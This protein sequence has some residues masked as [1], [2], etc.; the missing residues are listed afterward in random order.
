MKICWLGLALLAQ[1]PLAATPIEIRPLPVERPWFL[2]GGES[3]AALAPGE[4]VAVAVEVPSLSVKDANLPGAWRGILSVDLYGTTGSGE[5]KV[6]LE[7]ID[8]ASG[9]AF[10][11]GELQ[12]SGQA[13][14]AAWAPISSSE[15]GG[16]EVAKLF[17]GDKSTDWHSRYGANQPKP[18]HW[19]GVEFGSPQVIEGVRYLPRQSGFTNGVA[20]EY[21]VEVRRAGKSEWEVMEEGTSDRRRIAE[22]RESIDLRFDA[23]AKVE[24]FR[25]VVVSDWSGGGFGTAAELSAIGLELPARE[26]AVQA[27]NRVWLEV[28][29]D[30]LG[31]L[32]EKRFQLCLKASDGESVVAGT[33]RFCRIHEAPTEKL[34]G[35]SNGGTGPDKLG[36]GQLGF[37]GMTEH[38][39]TVLSVMRLRQGG[40]ADKAGLRVGDAIV[41]VSGMPLPVNDLNPGWTWF[42]QSHEAVLGHAAEDAL[43]SG[44][45]TLELGVLRDGAVTN[46]VMKLPRMKAF[47]TMDPANDPQAAVLLEDMLEWVRENQQPD[48]SWS[49]DVKRTTLASLALMATGKKKDLNQVKKAI[50]WGMAKYPTP[51]KHGNLGFWSGAYM[52][53][54]YSEWHLRTGDKRVLDALDAMRDWAFNGQHN[55]KWDV[56]ALGHGP[57]G[58]PY[59]QKALVAPAC[60]LLVFEALAQRCGMKSKLWELLM[61]YMEMAWSDPREGGHGAMG[62]NRSYKDLDEFWSR[63]GLFAMAAHL[64]GERQDMEDAMMQIM[65]ERRSWIRNSHAYGEPGGGLGLLGM[66]LC[67]PKRYQE[68]IKDYAWWFSMAWEPGYGL[69]FTTPHMGAPYMGEDDLMNVVY[70]LVLQGPKRSLHLTGLETK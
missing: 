41:S 55:S 66:N 19:V 32:T 42:H 65:Q 57:D 35:R 49:G 20:K 5:G 23:P 31:K 39:Q 43:T 64:R 33:P 34:L 53:I 37:D 8:P 62:Y 2:P 58:L 61:P 52:G 68:V 10:A 28:P 45:T 7:A 24:A 12:V 70:A 47:T 22:N 16:A 69:H 46:L 40:P 38:Q 51:E 11:K 21:R 44:K 17:D 15:Q 9:E 4:S 18:P 54:L 63:S 13:P 60:H 56:P 29:A 30:Q 1:A 50:D 14:R 26:E 48:G 25:F 6:A 36:A 3:G 67:A 59:D 27:M